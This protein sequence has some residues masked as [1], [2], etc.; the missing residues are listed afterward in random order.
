MTGKTWMMLATSVAA[1]VAPAAALAQ[2]VSAEPTTDTEPSTQPDPARD[3]IV[4]AQRRSENLQ[5]VAAAAT[6]IAGD[7]LQAKGVYRLSDLQFASPSLSVTDSGLTQNVNIRGIGLASGSPNAANGVATYVDG[8][9]QPP[10]VSTNSFYDIGSVEVF[11]GP[12]GTFVGSNSTGGA[13]FI[14]SRNPELGNYGGYFEGALGNYS[15]AATE[16]ALN[17]PLGSTLAVRVAGN[18]VNRDSFYRNA[19]TLL[20]RP[21]SLAE[22]AGRIGVYWEPSTAFNALLKADWAEKSTGGYAYRPIPGTRYAP[23]RS[24]DIRT[25]N[26]SDATANEERAFQSTLRLNYETAGGVTVRSITGYQNKRI[27]NLYDVDATNTTLLPRSTQTQFVRERQISEEINF[28]SPTTGA[29]SWIVGGYFQQ[30]KIDVDISNVTIPAPVRVDVDIAN[31]KH[32]YGVFAQATYKLTPRLSVDIGA[33]H[34]WYDIVGTGTVTLQPPNIFLANPG[35]THDDKKLT[36]K[37][38]LNW[39]PDVTNLIYGFV[40]RGYKSGGFASPTVQFQPE[41]VIDYEIGWKTSFFDRHVRTQ[42]GAFYYD[43][44]NFQLDAIDRSTGR[45][46]VTN[47]ASAT[48][49]GAEAQIQAHVAGFSVDGGAAYVDS[50]LSGTQFVDIRSVALAFPGV[51]NAPQCPAGQASAPPT[52]LDYAPFTATTAGGPNLFSPKWTWNIG[53]QYALPLGTATLTPRVNYGYIGS[54]WTYIAYNPTRDRIEGRGLLSASVRVALER[55]SFEVFGTNLTD[56]AYVSGQSGT[57]EFYGA[58]RQYGVRMHVD[59]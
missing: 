30:N 32:T 13:I 58:P 38:A 36:G 37:V 55:F 2:Q 18:Y 1:L 8:V 3:I 14:N 50:S 42:I 20:S 28:I 43:Y 6:A 49:K 26:Y 23:Y 25:L 53:A 10:I 21:G 19:P 17:V 46:G 51:S 7:S 24:G 57:N 59:F 22:H 45:S 15:Q 52:C 40:A 5:S 48:V 41:T 27:T 54:Q 39:T 31:T 34:S 35:G 33:R 16:G 9:F 12:Q 44:K 56:K 29:F 11:R 4:T 47:L